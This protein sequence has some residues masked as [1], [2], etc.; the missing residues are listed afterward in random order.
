[1]LYSTNPAGALGKMPKF[2]CESAQRGSK[3]EVV[4]YWENFFCWNQEAC[5][6]CFSFENKKKAG[7]L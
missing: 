1:L 4:F 6:G 7:V 5:E 2:F 3:Q